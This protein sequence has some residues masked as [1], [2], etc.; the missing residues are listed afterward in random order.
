[1]DNPANAIEGWIDEN[2]EAGVMTVTDFPLFPFGK[3]ITDR[4]GQTVVVYYDISKGKVT[5]VLPD[6][7]RAG[8]VKPRTSKEVIERITQLLDQ[9]GVRVVE[10]DVV[11][12]LDPE[13]SGRTHFNNRLVE[14]LTERGLGVHNKAVTLA[15]EAGHAILRFETEESRVRAYTTDYQEIEVE[16]HRFAFLLLQLL[17]A[18]KR[19]IESARRKVESEEIRCKVKGGGSNG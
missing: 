1:M 15:H 12:E 13:I 7:K 16:A 9:R 4:Q 11:D 8:A 6:S 17:E 19:V 5:H 10:V 14:V 2:F 3:L 18:P